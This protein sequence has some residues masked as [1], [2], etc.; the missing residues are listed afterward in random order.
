MT[1]RW[2]PLLILSGLFVV[3]ALAG[4][5]TIATVMGSR[6]SSD[7]VA[8]ART[9]RKAKEY[10]KAKLDYQIALK[11]DNRNPAL[12]VELADLC[13][14]WMREAPP[15]KKVEL[16]NLYVSALTSAANQGAKQVEPR[17]RLLTDA[18]VRDDQVE[19]IRKAREL[20]PID[21]TNADAAFVLAADELDS[22]SPNL[23]EVRRLLKVLEAETPRRVR[24][25]WI[26]ARV[27]GAT[28][29]KDQV[30]KVLARVRATTLPAG[31]SP[32]DQMALLRLRAIDL[33]ESTTPDAMAP[34]VDAV[35]R[36]ALAAASD[37]EIPSTRIARISLL[38]EHLQRGLITQGIEKP[39]NRETL[40][41]FGD[42]L[43]EVAESIFQKSLAVKGGADLNVYLAYADHLRFRDHRDRC[44]TIVKQALASPAAAKQG[45][46]EVGLGLHALAI[47]AYLANLDDT[48]RYES[49]TPHIKSLLDC[50]IERF[51]ALGHLFQGA[52]DLEKAGLV[53]KSAT[54]PA[55]KETAISKADQTKL[56]SS[57]L[58]HLRI[59]ANQLPHIAEAQA[60]YGVALILNQEPAM[61]RQ[62]LQKAQ[63]DGRLEPQ[64]QIWTAWSVVQ[65][66]YPEDAEPIVARLLQAVEQGRLPRSFEGTLHLLN[67]EIHQARKS[68]ADLKKAFEEYRKA[69]AN[70]QD[71]SP[72]VELRLAQMEVMLG[73]PNDALK[74]IDWLVSKGKAG[75]AAENLAILTLIDLKRDA[76]ARKRLDA[77]RAAYPD[78]SELATLEASMLV[79]AKQPEEADQILADFLKAVPDNVAAVQLRAQILANEM[80]RPAD[81]KK[82][83]GSVADRSENSAPMV[84]LALLELQGKDFE[85]ANATIARIRRRWKDAA[86]SDLLDAQLALARNDVAA[87]SNHFD[88]ALKKDP[89][90]K[91]V[92]FYKAQLDGRIDPEG[93]AKVFES[94]ASE[95]SIKEIDTGLSLVAASQS[96]LASMAM[97]SGDLD[98][99]IDRYREM[100]K[101]NNNAPAIVRTIKWQIV[102]AQAAKK[103][104]PAARAEMVGLLNDTKTPPTLE[105]RV[106][107]ATYYRLN[108]EDAAALAQVDQVLKADPTYPGAVV[109]RAEIL[110]R[111]G[112]HPEALAT[113]RKAIDA[114]TTASKQPPSV[115]YLMMAAV[116]ST[117]PPSETGFARALTVLDQG[118]DPGT[119]LH[120]AGEGQVQGVDPDAGAG[121]GCGVRGGQGQG[122]PDRSVPRTAPEHLPSPGRLHFGRASRR[123]DRRR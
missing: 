63:R 29:D 113:I 115:F 104:W 57:A 101:A 22:I 50:K 17:R 46:T 116:E 71:A 111:T 81:A 2:K 96:A 30:E 117:A 119:R 8:R 6:G 93:A 5:M 60:R 94:L 36:D 109:T 69:F 108:K 43:D 95:N 49:V 28:N 20:A 45:E 70:G 62:Y 26:A 9:E 122:E 23:S 97:E 120:R 92:Q 68:P 27:A 55:A 59:A 106:R 38:I 52:I 12:Y 114:A 82:L 39:A 123:R 4:L 15:E 24:T 44:L 67:G 87:A 31:A 10:E 40:N 85:A 88:A 41:T 51:Q 78:S 32:I 105:E 76:D 64:Y 107:A 56:R 18:L 54:D 11:T 14:E 25:D 35:K 58:F 42:S 80:K 74:R 3:V 16:H 73:R 48:Q 112:K 37:P 98:S 83:L 79:K 90:N 72:A 86:T 118:A 121:G 21:P 33:G 19:Q 91:L 77:A 66:G 103:E 13:Q 84:Q 61:G 100:L 75:P 65:A 99:A 53:D 89:N 1:V 102:A 34:K 7:F 110:A 47:E